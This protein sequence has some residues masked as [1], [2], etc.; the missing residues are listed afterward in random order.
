[1]IIHHLLYCSTVF[2]V[3]ILSFRRRG[4]N[5]ATSSSSASHE[6]SKV[7]ASMLA[8]VPPKIIPQTSSSEK[9]SLSSMLLVAIKFLPMGC[10]SKLQYI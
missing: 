2:D 5:I 9:V 10:L 7:H 8:S 1:M 3:P 4:G 6:S